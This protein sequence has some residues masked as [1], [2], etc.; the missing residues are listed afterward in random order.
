MVTL[1]LVLCFSP[2]LLFHLTRILSLLFSAVP[3]K[4]VPSKE[5]V[6]VITGKSECRRISFKFGPDRTGSSSMNS[7]VMSCSITCSTSPFTVLF[8]PLSPRL[9]LLDLFPYCS[10]LT[11]QTLSLTRLCFCLWVQPSFADPLVLGEMEGAAS[12]AWKKQARPVV[13]TRK[14]HLLLCSP[15]RVILR[16]VAFLF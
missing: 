1:F 7:L 13:L 16:I 2:T 3:I 11:N 15:E 8:A 4:A 10:I 6:P 5:L 12:G 14:I 9:F